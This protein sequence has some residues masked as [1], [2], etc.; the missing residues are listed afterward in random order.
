MGPMIFPAVHLERVVQ[1]AEEWYANASAKEVM[2]LAIDGKP[3]ANVSVSSN[4][5]T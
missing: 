5:S 1:V 2:A 3:G 4:T